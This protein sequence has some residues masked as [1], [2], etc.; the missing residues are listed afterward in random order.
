M[1]QNSKAKEPAD[2]T[3]GIIAAEGELNATDTPLA[4]ASEAEDQL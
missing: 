4:S 3:M 2:A 1:K